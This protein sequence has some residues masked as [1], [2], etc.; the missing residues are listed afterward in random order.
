[1]VQQTVRPYGQ[2]RI[3]TDKGF[4]RLQFSTSLS[5]TFYGKRQFFKGLRRKDNKPN[6]HWA[7]SLAARIQADIDHPDCLFDPS[8]AKYLELNP[9]NF[10]WKV[11]IS[12]FC[13]EQ[14]WPEFAEYKRRTGQIAETTYITR[15]N[16]TYIN[17]LKP[18]YSENLDRALAE[19]ILGDLLSAGVNR[20]NLKKM[21]SALKEA[22]DRA[23]EQGRFDKNPFIG[24]AKSIKPGK[25]SPQLIEEEDYR[26]FTREE[27]NAIV[28]EFSSSP[29]KSERQFANLVAFLFLT[30]CRLGEAFALKFE[31]LKPGYILFDESYSTE[32]KTTEKTKTSTTRLFRLSGYG[33]LERLLEYRK[34]IA[35]PGQEFVFVTDSGA[36]LNRLKLA[37]AWHG[38]EKGTKEKPNYQTGV[39]TR[40][41]EQGIVS[42]YLKPSSTRHTFITLQIQSG[43]DVK[44][45]ADSVGNSV[46]TIYKHYLGVNREAAIADL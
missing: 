33:K 45:L 16:R 7:E 30:G 17:W 4:L 13:L 28:N 3:S 43:T 34:K 29:H 39:V 40:L 22:C 27:R 38:K 21:F 8:L 19:K 1:M 5:Q 42:R 46:D 24:L 36:Q 44:L 18:Y 2:V 32:A 9:V 6:R 11:P 26:A 23:I 14:L 25:K 31:D 10:G 35:Q 15:Y 20:G 37:A 12:F 41:V